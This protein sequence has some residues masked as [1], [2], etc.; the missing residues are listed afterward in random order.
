MS[1]KNANTVSMTLALWER[2]AKGQ[3]KGAAAATATKHYTKN[4]NNNKAYAT[5][6]LRT[7]RCTNLIYLGQWLQSKTFRS[8]LW[9][10]TRFCPQCVA[11]RCAVRICRTFEGALGC[12]YICM[13]QVLC[14]FVTKVAIIFGINLIIFVVVCSVTKKEYVI[15][16]DCDWGQLFVHQV[17]KWVGKCDN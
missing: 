16:R 11:V 9:R 13:R 17:V 15:W 14:E 1:H 7:R 6:K 2:A 4:N 5:R 12:V 10:Y 3:Q 8:Y